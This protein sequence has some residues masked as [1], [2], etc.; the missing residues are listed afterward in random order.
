MVWYGKMWREH[1]KNKVHYDKLFCHCEI[2]R[3]AESR[4][5]IAESNEVCHIE[6]SE[7]SL[8]IIF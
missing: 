4:T 3:I 1:D 6:R 8:F 2:L 7:I 5:K